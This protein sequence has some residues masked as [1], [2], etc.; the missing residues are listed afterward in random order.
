MR[1][2]L[3][4]SFP[5]KH[6]D[7]AGTGGRGPL[8]SPVRAHAR[9][10]GPPTGARLPVSG[11]DD[12]GAEESDDK[13]PLSANEADDKWAGARAAPL[14]CNN[15]RWMARR[16][17]PPYAGNRSPVGSARWEGPAPR[18]PPLTRGGR[19][20]PGGPGPP[21]TK[22]PARPGHSACSSCPG[23]APPP[24]SHVL[25][26]HASSCHPHRGTHPPAR[27]SARTAMR[28][29]APQSC[30]HLQQ[31]PRSWAWNVA[32]QQACLTHSCMCTAQGRPTPTPS[33]YSRL[34]TY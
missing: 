4:P 12:I 17:P 8:G 27:I 20:R 31:P 9:V 25:P 23:A 5:Q 30:T 10:A 3:R 15:R 1:L 24:P 18:R 34:P 22:R 21:G 13:C 29:H 7:R 28:T 2:Y 14:R 19:P 11:A 16:P 33:D 6:H 26:C 32:V